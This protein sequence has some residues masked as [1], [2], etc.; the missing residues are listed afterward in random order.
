M[1]SNKK[2]ITRGE[3]LLGICHIFGPRENRFHLYL[4]H[5]CFLSRLSPPHPMAPSF[6]FSIWKTYLL[7]RYH[8]SAKG[9]L[10]DRVSASLT[11][12]KQ[13]LVWGCL[14]HSPTL[15]V[16][17]ACLTTRVQFG[18]F[19]L[20]SSF[21]RDKKHYLDRTGHWRWKGVI[22]DRLKFAHVICL[23]QTFAFPPIWSYVDS[24]P[25]PKI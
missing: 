6:S 19:I 11:K 2:K 16:F 20:T 7:K 22:E 14:P 13:S 17:L 4:T 21:Y 8:Q 12:H 24:V 10:L 25:A 5:A 9:T 15:C 18:I 23:S 1:I 3:I